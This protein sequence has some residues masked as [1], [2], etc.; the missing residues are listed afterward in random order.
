MV[1]RGEFKMVTMRSLMTKTF[2]PMLALA[3][4]LPLGNV[5]TAGEITQRELMQQLDRND[6][7]MIVDVRR[8]DEFAAGHVPGARNIPHNEIAARLHELGGKQH[9]EVVVY[10]ESG[11]RAAI[12]QG[13]LE[14][15]GFT[16]VRHLE[17]DMQSWRKRNLPQE[18]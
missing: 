15:A 6:P 18:E 16:Q 17:G 2:I 14:Q 1:A 8:P 10:C 5:A 13:I 7:P 9:E 4:L 3:L 12:A 11:R